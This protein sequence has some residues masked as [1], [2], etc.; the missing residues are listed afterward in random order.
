GHL[1][2]PMMD[3]AGWR[4]RDSII[5]FGNFAKLYDRYGELVGEAVDLEA[6]KLHH[7]A[8]TM[9]NS[10]VFS[11]RLRHPEP[12]TDYMTYLQWCNETNLYTTEALGEYLDID[13]PTV[14]E[15]EPRPNQTSNAHHHLALSLRAIDTGNEYLRYKI[16]IAFRLAGHLDRYNEIGGAV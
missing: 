4:M 5:P 7:I 13:L 14:E 3:L 15:P 2:D 9:S 16:R 10:L 8:F 11:D 12:H 1:G 6:I